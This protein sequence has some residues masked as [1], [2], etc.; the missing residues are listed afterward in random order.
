MQLPQDQHRVTDEEGGS[1]IH[2]MFITWSFVTM[3]CP[4]AML[5]SSVGFEPA[6][7]RPTLGN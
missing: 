3:L 6:D 2:S 5:S 4:K 1:L 7:P